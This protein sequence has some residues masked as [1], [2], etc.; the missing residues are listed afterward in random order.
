[1]DTF[2]ILIRLFYYSPPLGLVVCL[3][4]L[5]IHWKRIKPF[6]CDLKTFLMDNVYNLCHIRKINA[7]IQNA[8]SNC[9]NNEP[10]LRAFKHVIPLQLKIDSNTEDV[11]IRLEKGKV[12][13][14]IRSK[15]MDQVVNAMDLHFADNMSQFSVVRD[16]IK[17]ERALELVCLELVVKNCKMDGALAIAA[18]QFI[19]KAKEDEEISSMFSILSDLNGKLKQTE[20]LLDR[21]LLRI[22]IV[23]TVEVNLMQLGR[24]LCEFTK[25]LKKI[26]TKERGDNINPTFR[27]DGLNMSIVLIGRS[28]TIRNYGCEPYISYIKGAVKEG[29][30]VFYILAMGR[31]N[32]W[33]ADEV[34]G[35]VCR[36]QIVKKTDGYSDEIA[37][38]GGQLR[39]SCIRLESL[40]STYNPFVRYFNTY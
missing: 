38:K 27:C 9:E 23:E 8:F 21:R 16:F 13:G 18:S 25:F 22:L 34:V 20:P 11:K 1:M 2:E 36:E 29:V 28:K 32:C 31:L 37:Y 4:Y 24:S 39:I 40:S 6:V 3:V 12:L 10:L 15:S 17:L 5:M 19:N 14:I 7:L 26:E 33:V 35:R 30:K